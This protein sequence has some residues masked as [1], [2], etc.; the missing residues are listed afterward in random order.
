MTVE[1]LKNKANASL[2]NVVQC[3][4]IIPCMSICFCEAFAYLGFTLQPLLSAPPSCVS[5]CVQSNKGAT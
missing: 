3:S 2:H 5:S 4:F 1:L